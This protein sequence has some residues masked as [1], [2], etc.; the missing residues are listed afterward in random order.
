MTGQILALKAWPGG[1]WSISRGRG[2]D[3][4][5]HKPCTWKEL[6]LGLSNVANSHIRSRKARGSGGLTKYGAKMVRSGC[7][8]LE[9]AVRKEYLS[10]L[11]LT[12]PTS[13]SGLIAL[14]TS[15]LGHIVNRFTQELTRELVRKGLS[16]EYVYVIEEQK[17]GAPH[18][19]MIFQG[20][21]DRNSMRKNR[22][23][24]KSRG[25]GW[26]IST[27]KVDELWK[28]TLVNAG[29]PITSVEA[30]CNIQRVRKSV[31]AYMSK[32]MTKG[33]KPTGSN[34]TAAST[35]RESERIHPASWWGMAASI[36]QAIKKAMV[37]VVRAVSSGFNWHRGLQSMSAASGTIYAH[38]HEGE[39]GE[40]KAL[41]GRVK[42]N[43]VRQLLYEFNNL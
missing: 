6:I 17:R 36:R 7:A 39:D 24:S 33:T 20:R 37:K 14:M 38:Y 16:G 35:S 8:G 41:V 19:H 3:Y 4:P 28:G 25:W 31:V 2:A 11:T 43:R 15:E 12:L 21:H 22:H 1:D 9:Q 42:P 5:G 26:A 32:Y 29:Y 30:A 40:F 27:A 10:F 18:V 34:D 23:T 13:D